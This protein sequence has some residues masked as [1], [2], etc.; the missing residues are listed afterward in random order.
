MHNSFVCTHTYACVYVGVMLL[1]PCLTVALAAFPFSFAFASLQA[2][3]LYTRFRL[4]EIENLSLDICDML[5]S[6]SAVPACGCVAA[7]VGG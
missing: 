7:W 5:L 3:N 2:T 1:D 4:T 6:L